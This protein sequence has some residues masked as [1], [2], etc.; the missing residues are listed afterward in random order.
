MEKAHV[1]TERGMVEAH[2]TSNKSRLKQYVSHGPMPEIYLNDGQR[3]EIELYNSKTH[4]CLAKIWI[5]NIAT[6]SIII[7]P[8]ERLF[9]ERY[10][11][12]DNSFVFGSYRVAN[13]PLT[14][15]AVA[16][17]GSIRIEFYSECIVNI[18]IIPNGP[19]IPNAPNTGIYYP[20]SSPTSVQDWNG[21]NSI[22]TGQPPSTVTFGAVE[23]API[24]SADIMTGII[25]KG[26]GTGQVFS[27]GYGNFVGYPS[28]IFNYK[29][30]PTTCKPKD[31]S[32]LRK[33]C[34]QCNKKIK[35][36]WKFCPQCGTRC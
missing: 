12:S 35:S 34:I 3:F 18:P 27:V 25:E 4:R 21:W 1:T 29:L 8:G 6:G 26:A 7:R 30:L 28:K 36:S 10:L 17:N 32:E 2:I 33:Y 22:G 14:Q 20:A 15:Q 24:K 13:D 16:N 31:V 9:L 19:T 11:D 5:N 23:D